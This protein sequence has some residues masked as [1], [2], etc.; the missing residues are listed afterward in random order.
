MVGDVLG[1]V[2]ACQQREILPML[3]LNS[4]ADA[5]MRKRWVAQGERK[6]QRAIKRAARAANYRPNGHRERARRRR[7][8]AAGRLRR[9]NGLAA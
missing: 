9:E 2:A 5:L 4:M 7:Q 3:N 8:I 6:Y 1:A